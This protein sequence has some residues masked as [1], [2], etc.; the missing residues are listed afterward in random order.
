MAVKKAKN[1]GKPVK[2]HKGYNVRTMFKGA[3][4]KEPSGKFGIFAG[5]NKLDEQ[6]SIDAA[7]TAIDKLV[8]AK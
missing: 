7:V 6:P 8:A 2:H 3:G 4:K 1:Y 5:K